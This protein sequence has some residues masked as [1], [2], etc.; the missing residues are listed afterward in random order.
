V[1]GEAAR[2]G[3]DVNNR[4]PTRR[5]SLA[6]PDPSSAGRRPVLPTPHVYNHAEDDGRE[7][8]QPRRHNEGVLSVRRP[9]QHRGHRDFRP[10]EHHE[11]VGGNL[12]WPTRALE[13]V[14]PQ[15]KTTPRA[16]A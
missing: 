3:L 13:N 14:A 2:E 10:T 7:G 16:A 1:A 11:K 12:Q 6:R 9:S 5:R 8:E 4:R 15:P